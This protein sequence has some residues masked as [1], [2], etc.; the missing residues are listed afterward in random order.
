MHPKLSTVGIS[1]L[2]S[3]LV[4][5]CNAGPDYVKPKVAMPSNYKELAK[6]WRPAKPQDTAE[7]GAWWTIFNNPQLN[8]L[9]NKL[10]INNQNIA[11]AAAQYQEAQALVAQAKA[12]YFPLVSGSVV[13]T[14]QKQPVS[15]NSNSNSRGNSSV[16]SNTSTKPYTTDT[17]TLGATWEPDLWGA[18][19]RAV[20][21][22]VAGAE[23]SAAQ[24]AS[25]RLSMQAALAQ[26]YLQLSTLDLNQQ[27]LDATV[28][29][30]KKIL[31]L[32]KNRYAAGVAA[33]A[34]ILQAEINLN[35]ATA[36][37]QDNHIARAQYEHA[38][39]VLIGEPASIFSLPVKRLALTPPRV[40]VNLPAELLERRPDIAA[41]ERLMAQANAEIGVAVSA[42]YPILTLSGDMGY[43]NNTFKHLISQ[44]TQF[45]ALGPQ[46]A[47]TF[48]DGGLRS[49]KVQAARANYTGSIATY[50]QTV[51]TALQNVE[52]NL[53][54]VRILA[55]EANTQNKFVDNTK[56]QFKIISN[57]Y[58]AGTTDALGVLNVK[59][60]LLIAENDA[61][62]VSGR[63]FVATVGLIMALGG[64]WHSM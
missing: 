3:V 36:L 24:L 21:A 43:Q 40:P 27:N 46:L 52:D 26:T 4:C 20:E 56:G 31:Q 50:R 58:N 8:A 6:Y 41:A 34:D 62:A 29:A 2:M 54:A 49:A 16:S 25:V 10:N 11:L 33:Q 19:R 60:A 61:I 28:L 9:E 7:R 37:A 35:T 55:A 42:Y 22:N 23:A 64:G 32:I 45:W 30:Y 47:A 53:A 51:L 12:G 13:N 1:I 59:I 48:F 57:A 44:P 17:L 14:R 5:A 63:R 15:K 39:A 18:V 38:I